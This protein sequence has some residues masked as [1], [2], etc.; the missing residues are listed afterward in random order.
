MRLDGSTKIGLAI[1]LALGVGGGAAVLNPDW[2]WVGTTMMS[3]SAAGLVAL[4]IHHWWG[5]LPAFGFGRI[6]LMTAAR[7]MFEHLETRGLED[8]DVLP[9]TNR[10][11]HFMWV[12]VSLGQE[13]EIA[14][15]GKRRPSQ[16]TRR[17]SPAALKRL[18]PL[19]DGTLKSP[20]ASDGT[21]ID[22]VCLSRREVRKHEPAPVSAEVAFAH[23]SRQGD[24]RFVFFERHRRTNR[25]LDVEAAKRS[26]VNNARPLL[27]HSGDIG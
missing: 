5:R 7:W 11:E 10:L 14:I 19:A 8:S 24:E 27:F 4:A 9:S 23:V 1:A 12:L 22:D 2:H 3:F 15:Y 13:G 20:A 17:L 25:S 16:Q 6:P 18:Q 26:G 21:V